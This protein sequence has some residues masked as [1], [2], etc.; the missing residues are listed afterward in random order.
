MNRWWLK[1]ARYGRSETGAFIQ[2]GILVLA[3]I[4]L[5]L[6]LPW[7]LKLIV[8]Y[9]L[10]EKPLP[11]YLSWIR[12]LPGAQSPN[13]ML[14]WLAAATVG[15]FLTTRC[16]TIAQR[17]VETG[18]GSRMVYA[19]ATDLF[20]H[21]QRRSLLLHYQAKTGDL[22]KRVTA[23][24]GCVRELVM[25]VFVPTVQSTLL[26]LGMLVVMWQMS[27][28]LAIFAL[29]LSI[30]LLIIIRLLAEPLSQNRYCEQEL[31][32]QIYSL[33]EQTLSAMPL[34]QSFG[35]EQHHNEHFDS[36][37]R[38]TIW[39]NLRYELTGHQ[40]KVGTSAVTSLA[41]ACVMIYGGL[42]VRDG[43]LSVGSLLVLLAYFAA[44]YSPL[45]TL[46]YLTEG[47][48][49][50]KAGA[51]R[52]LELLDEESSPVSDAPTARPLVCERDARGAVIRYDDVAFGYEPNRAVLEGVSFEVSA[53][54]TVA[55]V[56]ET[57]AGKSTLMSLL[58]RFFDPWRGAIYVDGIDI[59]Q[60]TLA[61][62]RSNIAYL[63]Q[64]PF[65]LPLSITENIAYG[66]PTATRNEIVAAA[67]AAKADQFIR[68]L[69]HGYD[70]VIGERGATLSAGQKQ[71]LSLARALLKEAPILILDEPTSALDPVTEA[72]IFDDVCDLFHSRT[73]FV[74]AHRFSTI[75]R[76]TT[77]IVV[78]NGSVVETGSPQELFSMG[79]R[80]YQLY[81]L[82]FG[83][84]P[85]GSTENSCVSR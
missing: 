64:T 32:G 52:V 76:A 39:A 79:G 72:S 33:A 54:E 37:A 35:R 78:E 71:R 83:Q 42:A 19:L 59:R 30:P 67:S 4:V 48:A 53:G 17:Y 26:L 8:D 9:V 61:S 24:T 80:Y 73:T 45:E 15:L 38:R 28:G 40:F 77:V 70:T 85:L 20:F 43:R 11:Q 16:V 34:V 63:P 66:R 55:V 65:L 84:Q 75:Q 82:Q 31:Q 5:G 12:S 22:I 56:G 36:L 60:V 18:A 47:F 74:I 49:S 58:L 25:R 10:A 44:L 62:L 69:P 68:Q 23:D 7:P 27:P 14:A 29:L 3:G 6:L 46:A 13:L 81:Q 41:T 21:L 57:G 50:A 2:I 1:L 51:R